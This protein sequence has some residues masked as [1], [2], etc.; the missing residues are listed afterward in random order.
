MTTVLC[1]IL[2]M[3]GMYPEIQDKVYNEAI[4]VLGPDGSIKYKDLANLKYI[5]RCIYEVS[6]TF[7]SNCTNNN[8]VS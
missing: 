3:L 5:K 8:K 4:N 6:N 7:I 2:I 1:F